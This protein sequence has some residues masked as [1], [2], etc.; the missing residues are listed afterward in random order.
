MGPIRPRCRSGNSCAREAV[1][2]N[3]MVEELSTAARQ[4]ASLR[5]VYKKVCPICG[6]EFEG[7]AKRVYDRHACQ[8]KAYRRRMRERQASVRGSSGATR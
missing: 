4:L 3:E 5:R 7:I 1:L 6:I 8:V 2:P